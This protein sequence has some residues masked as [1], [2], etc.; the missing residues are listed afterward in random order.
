MNLFTYNV[1]LVFWQKLELLIFPTVVTGL[2]LA[3]WYSSGDKPTAAKLLIEVISPLI[4]GLLLT[5]IF[6]RELK[7]RTAEI[8]YTKSASPAKIFYMRY[9]LVLFYGIIVLFVIA[10]FFLIFTDFFVM[11]SFY[12]SIPVITFVTA[13]GMILSIVLGQNV[14]SIGIILL[15]FIEGSLG[16]R[17]LPIFLFLETFLP[18]Y[19]H[20]WVNRA[21]FIILSFA[22]WLLGFY[23]LR[24]PEKIMR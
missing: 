18:E 6:P 13:L 16:S 21:V 4:L 12:A 22:L 1:K 15:F 17:Y 7:W 3:M 20:F 2:V 10:I 14:A 8:I 24:K 19:E 9:F 23:I 11:K 5:D